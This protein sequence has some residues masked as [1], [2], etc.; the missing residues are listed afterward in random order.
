MDDEPLQLIFG[1]IILILIINT[2][3]TW[4]IASTIYSPNF[5]LTQAPSTG[6]GDENLISGSKDTPDAATSGKSPTPTATPI[7]RPSSAPTP[8]KQEII[9]YVTV[10]A[11]PVQHE[12]PHILLQPNIPDRTYPNYITIYSISEQDISGALPRISFNLVNPPLVLDYDFTP[13][14]SSDLKLVEFKNSSGY[15]QKNITVERP[16][17]QS[18]FIVVVRN[19]ETG[20]ILH[21]DGMGKLYSYQTPKRL[22][23]QV[24]GNYEFDFSGMFGS[25]NLTMRVKKEGNIP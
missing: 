21:E 13:D 20:Q 19:K 15:Q 23:L 1:V 4:T 18:Y 9:T 25:I 16:N 2:I 17:E 14:E 10:E 22:L 3:A 8:K 5:T 7:T 6:A 24:T 11:L 12:T